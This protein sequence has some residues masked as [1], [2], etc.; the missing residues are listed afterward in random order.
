M[1]DAAK[2]TKET[3]SVPVAREVVKAVAEYAGV[4]VDTVIG[5]LAGT[6]APELLRSLAE[7]LKAERQARAKDALAH[8][9]NPGD[10]LPGM[11]ASD[12]EHFSQLRAIAGLTPDGG[13][14]IVPAKE[15]A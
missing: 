12:P 13:I 14:P 6:F 9:L 2:K 4:T 11:A 15:G 1:A 7:E 10:T 3:Y 5:K 8:V